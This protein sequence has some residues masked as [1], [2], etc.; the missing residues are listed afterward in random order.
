M[1]KV[2]KNNLYSNSAQER[3]S[4]PVVYCLL[5]RNSRVTQINQSW[6]YSNY[7]IN[8]GDFLPFSMQ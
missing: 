8:G 1:N 6:A 7:F 5:Y 2:Q 3:T 4:K